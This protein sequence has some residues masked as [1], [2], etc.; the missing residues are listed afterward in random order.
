MSIWKIFVGGA[1]DN[2]MTHIV[3]D[4]LSR[5]EK[6]NPKFT[7]RYFSWTDGIELHRLLTGDA[8]DGHVTLVGHSLGGNAIYWA[9]GHVP[10]VDVLIGIDPVG[11]IRR[12]WTSIRAGAK[13][14]LNVRA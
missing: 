13:V 14:W 5:Y 1:A 2:S 11:P 3:K 8:K 4:Y 7:C 12:G 9:M 10:V 6:V